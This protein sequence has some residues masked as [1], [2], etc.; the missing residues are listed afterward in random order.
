[1]SMSDGLRLGGNSESAFPGVRLGGFTTQ[2]WIPTLKGFPVG[3]I[4][5]VSTDPLANKDAM[6]NKVLAILA[7]TPRTFTAKEI[8]KALRAEGLAKEPRAIAV[9]VSQALQVLK[10]RRLAVSGGH[11]WRATVH[12]LG[13]GGRM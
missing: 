4:K 1:M 12:T 3:G 2:I 6:A 11:L 8:V 10:R 13:K 9:A 5:L 7:A